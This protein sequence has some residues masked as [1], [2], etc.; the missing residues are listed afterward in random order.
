LLNSSPYHLKQMDKQKLQTRASS[1]WSSVKLMKIPSG[2]T[3]SL[4][5][6]YGHTGWHAMEQPKHHLIN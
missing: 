1:N 4:T 6:H 5:R 2:G 3:Q